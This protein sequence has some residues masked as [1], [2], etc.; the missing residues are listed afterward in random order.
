MAARA[1]RAGRFDEVE[2]HNHR[3]CFSNELIFSTRNL[4]YI[5]LN[6]SL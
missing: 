6:Q 5:H 2:P 4:T 1:V 3:G